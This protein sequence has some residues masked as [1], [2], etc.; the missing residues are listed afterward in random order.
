VIADVGVVGEP[1]KGIRVVP[2]IPTGQLC[3]LHNNPEQY[4][5]LAFLFFHFLSLRRGLPLKTAKDLSDIILNLY[6]LCYYKFEILLIPLH[7]Q[8]AV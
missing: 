2:A 3:Y 8:Q 1:G 4:T 5:R 6:Y 7:K